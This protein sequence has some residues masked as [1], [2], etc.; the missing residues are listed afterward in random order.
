MQ[1]VEAEI[2][3]GKSK[4]NTKPVYPSLVILVLN[5][6][7]T[8][9]LLCVKYYFQCWTKV[10]SLYSRFSG[11]ESPVLQFLNRDNLTVLSEAINDIA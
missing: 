10:T 3:K 11:F 9:H 6:I 2:R 1:K 8:G 5:K 4:T 7:L